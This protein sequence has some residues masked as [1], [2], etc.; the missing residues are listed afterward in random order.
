M[1][2]LQESS[3]L[4]SDSSRVAHGVAAPLKRACNELLFRNVYT[5][6][7]GIRVDPSAS[8]CGAHRYLAITAAFLVAQS[9]PEGAVG[10]F[11]LQPTSFSILKAVKP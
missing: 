6:T 8:R 5:Y 9:E 11:I 1:K 10:L 4:G 3:E 7:T 2:Q